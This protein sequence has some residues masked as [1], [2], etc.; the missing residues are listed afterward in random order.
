MS[1]CLLFIFLN[2]ELSGL[3]EHTNSLPNLGSRRSLELRWHRHGS[4]LK[5][6]RGVCFLDFSSQSW[7][8]WIVTLIHLQSAP[9]L[10]ALFSSHHL[11]RGALWLH[12]LP[13][14]QDHLPISRSSTYICKTPFLFVI[15][16][17]QRSKIDSLGGCGWKGKHSMHWFAWLWR[18]PE[19]AGWTSRLKPQQRW[20]CRAWG[21]F[22]RCHFFS[23]KAFNWF[24]EAHPQT[25]HNLLYLKF[26][27]INESRVVPVSRLVFD[28]AENK[29]SAGRTVTVE[30]IDSKQTITGMR[31]THTWGMWHSLPM[32]SRTFLE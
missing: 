2:H 21:F 23:G 6:P 31:V 8:P 14:T 29:Q 17:T 24:V 19:S 28:K 11:L 1:H 27:H 16:K 10:Q 9:Q 13:G 20:C 12:G 4:I 30:Q 7:M 15:I 5:F 18:S 25:E 3:E 22:G 32:A 26:T